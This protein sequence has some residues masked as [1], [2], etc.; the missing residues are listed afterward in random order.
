MSLEPFERVADALLGGRL[1]CATPE[2]LN[3]PLEGM[4]GHFS[5]GLGL[6]SS[7]DAF[8]KESLADASEVKREVDR[9]R[10]CCLSGRPDVMQMWSYYAGG[11]KGICLEV[12]MSAYTDHL[13]NVKYIKEVSGLASKTI[14]DRLRFKHWT[15]RHEKEYRY[16]RP[17]ADQG[18]FVDVKI[19]SVLI[20]A[21]TESRFLFPLFE[22]CKHLNLRYDLALFGND[23]DF[24]RWQLNPDLAKLLV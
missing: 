3:D 1:Y 16:L 14:R 6:E 5:P 10:I 2:E 12:D 22:L 8:V 15:W 7:F 18:K 19:E 11:H 17:D 13:V 4:L 9:A 24:I 23:G 21:S 20:A